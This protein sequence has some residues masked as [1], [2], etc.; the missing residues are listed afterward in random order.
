MH[1]VV[2]PVHSQY[3][4]AACRSIKTTE[5]GPQAVGVQAV[6][7]RQVGDLVIL[8]FLLLQQPDVAALIL[9]E[10][11]LQEVA[12]GVAAH[13]A[14]PVDR[15]AAPV[16]GPVRSG[17]FQIVGPPRAWPAREVVDGDAAAVCQFD[18]GR[19]QGGAKKEQVPHIVREIAARVRPE[20]QD[21]RGFLIEQHG[22]RG[23][24]CHILAHSRQP[25]RKVFVQPQVDVGLVADEVAVGRADAAVDAPIPDAR[26]GLLDEVAPAARHSRFVEKMVNDGGLLHEG[27]QLRGILPGG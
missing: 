15:A 3:P 16:Q 17:V 14:E 9:A 22:R 25:R 20:R 10:A 27:G 7:T 12:T 4:K 8:R 6:V 1:L 24:E 13:V 26:P 23:I 21:Q 5:L 18:A 2:P 19:Q 11:L